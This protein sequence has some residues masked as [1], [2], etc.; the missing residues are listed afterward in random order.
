MSERFRVRLLAALSLTCAV[1]PSSC[2]QRGDVATGVDDEQTP[3]KPKPK[4]P[5]AAKAWSVGGTPT[6]RRAT[7]ARCT[8]AAA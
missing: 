7:R 2:R 5:E 1:A 6:G 4:P 8:R 3:K